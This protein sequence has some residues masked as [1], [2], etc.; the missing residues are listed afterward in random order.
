MWT[1]TKWFCQCTTANAT[2]GVFINNGSKRFL[3]MY[4]LIIPSPHVMNIF[5]LGKLEFSHLRYGG[6]TRHIYTC[7]RKCP[8]KT[9]YIYA[10]S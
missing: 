1:L 5:I 10:C 7:S 4:A 9:K 2:I 3:S 6:Y 8:G